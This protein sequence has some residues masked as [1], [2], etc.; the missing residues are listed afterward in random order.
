MAL[1]HQP[2]HPTPKFPKTP[3][4]NLHQTFALFK[5]S[6]NDSNLVCETTAH[7]DGTFGHIKARICVLS[8]PKQ[9]HLT[10]MIMCGVICWIKRAQLAVRTGVAPNEAVLTLLQWLQDARQHPSLVSGAVFA[11]LVQD[12][13]G[14][15]L[16]A[17]EV[18]LVFWS[19]V[20]SWLIWKCFQSQ[21][22]I[23]RL[24]CQFSSYYG[25]EI[26]SL[27]GFG[28]PHYLW[29]YFTVLYILTSCWFLCHGMQSTLVS[30]MLEAFVLEAFGGMCYK[31]WVLSLS[32]F[33]L[34][35][36]YG[37]SPM[38]SRI[39]WIAFTLSFHHLDVA[40]RIAH[41]G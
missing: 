23:H 36:I 32:Y 27:H 18:H 33:G 15:S 4:N 29:C 31:Q 1:L 14:A 13:S 28:G 12:V 3:T 2:R 7:A 5:T 37:R 9:R 11:S 35:G 38:Y 25:F 41:P 8:L 17:S 24:I 16:D 19:I 22:I 30:T 39:L 26:S 34:G 10:V 21:H 6:T 20:L 40:R